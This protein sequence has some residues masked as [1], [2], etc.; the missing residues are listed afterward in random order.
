MKYVLWSFEHH[1]WW[2]PDFVGYTED[3]RQAG[4]YSAE[5]AGRIV[6]NSILGEEVA[7]HERT[8][9]LNGRPTVKSLW[10]I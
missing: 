2:G 8:A 9:E 6:T 3:L 7:L 5:E 1:A 10:G 4:R